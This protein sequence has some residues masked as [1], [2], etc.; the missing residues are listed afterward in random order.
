MATRPFRPYTVARRR[1]DDEVT[2]TAVVAA[3]ASLPPIHL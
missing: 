1:R 2:L 3:V